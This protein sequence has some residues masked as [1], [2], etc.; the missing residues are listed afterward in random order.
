MAL[1]ASIWRH[2]HLKVNGISTLSGDT[3][4][5]FPKPAAC[6][7]AGD[8]AM[9][10]DY[11]G[12]TGK[13]FQLTPDPAFYFR[14][15]SHRKA[16]SCLGHGLAHGEGV[17]VVTGDVG[18]GKS[19]LVA[20]LMTTIDPQHLTAAQIA[21][22]GVDEDE[23]IHVVAQGFGIHTQG[24]DKA[25]A[26]SSIE[27]FL[28]SEARAGRRCLLIVDDAHKL[29]IEAL[30]DLRVLS[31][32]QFA[33][34]SLLQAL[35]LGQPELGALLKSHAALGPLRQ[36]VVAAHH[37]E[38][39]KR[40]EIEPYINHRLERV[41]WSGRPQFD[42]RVF[43]EL[44]AASAG[45]PLRVDQ[46]TSR[47]LFL[48]AV[49]RR[50]RIDGMI[51]RAA[52]D[53]LAAE[54][55]LLAELPVTRFATDP[56]TAAPSSTGDERLFDHETVAAALAERDAQIAELRQA[57][58]KLAGQQDSAR[59]ASVRAEIDALAVQVAAIEARIEEQDQ[60]LRRTLAMLIDW[61]DGESA[62]S[63]AA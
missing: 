44:H 19:M 29:S 20:H 12:L 60:A 42:Q 17:I 5:Q 24:H 45:I 58:V 63:K 1:Q 33:G 50:S 32:F 11:Y 31:G 41:G 26:L 4:R 39:M 47:L 35:L 59:S 30:E 36:R 48:G 22:C 53:D 6:P 3:P 7:A 18:S 23:L 34:R 49:E 54:R 62:P 52:L 2:R 38:P 13:P 16:L 51:L 9:F 21:T 27:G 10:D 8:P 46:V 56:P 55:A 57:V 14:S 25:G 37:L 40:A 15:E 43:V 61:I 28:H